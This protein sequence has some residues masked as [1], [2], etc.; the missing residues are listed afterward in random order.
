MCLSW[1]PLALP[2]PLPSIVSPSLSLSLSL[3]PPP[4]LSFCLSRRN[5]RQEI[6]I[7]RVND[8]LYS[9]I[10]VNDAR[11]FTLAQTPPR[12]VLPPASTPR[13]P[14]LFVS[15]ASRVSHPH[16]IDEDTLSPVRRIELAPA[17]S[18]TPLDCP[19]I[20]NLAPRPPSFPFMANNSD[21]VVTHAAHGAQ[22]TS[23]SA[24]INT[25]FSDSV[26]TNTSA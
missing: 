22:Q 20:P 15:C 5:T 9:S 19:P 3:P 18:P 23:S 7:A 24:K 12:R 4:A 2:L 16:T 21:L 11:I 6:Y 26:A 8:A 14:P 13:A 1:A 10:G 25:F 17:N